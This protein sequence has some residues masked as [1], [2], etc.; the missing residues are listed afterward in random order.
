[1]YHNFKRYRFLIL[2]QS[3]LLWT[4]KSDVQI[5]FKASL[6]LANNCGKNAHAG[7]NG[8]TFFPAIFSR[9]YKYLDSEPQPLDEDSSV[10]I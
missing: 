4:A 6:R 8:S 10:L 9:Q 7:N 3:I 1:M 5:N 2:V